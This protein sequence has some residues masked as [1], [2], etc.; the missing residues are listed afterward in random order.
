MY[1][2][3]SF[4]ERKLWSFSAAERRKSSRNKNNFFL[5]LSIFFFD[6][7]SHSS[8]SVLLCFSVLSLSFPLP[9]FHSSNLPLFFLF[10]SHFLSAIIWFLLGYIRSPSCPWDSL[11]NSY[12][13]ISSI[14]GSRFNVSSCFNQAPRNDLEWVKDEQISSLSAQFQRSISFASAHFSSRLLSLSLSFPLRV[15]F[16]DEK[17]QKRTVLFGYF[18]GLFDLF[19][20]FYFFEIFF[21]RETT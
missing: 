12:S 10:L 1:R 7:S 17:T 11:A 5:F 9:L 14:T 2:K 8:I 6:H 3:L 13:K 19:F 18:F 16:V 15:F 21:F 4:G 20:I